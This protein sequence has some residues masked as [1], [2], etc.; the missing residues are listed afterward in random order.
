MDKLQVRNSKSARI[1]TVAVVGADGSG[2]STVI[3]NI[4]QSSVEPVKCV[5]MGASVDASNVSLPTT[6]LLQYIKKRRMAHFVDT[7]GRLP[8]ATLMSEEMRAKMPRGKIAK[9]VG[10]VNRVAEEWYRQLHVWAYQLRG[11]SV[12]C[13]RHFL[14]EYCPDAVSI[15]AKDQWLSV[16]I[17]SWLLRRLFPKPDLVI[18]L[19]APV[20]TL[21]ARKSE[22]PLEHLERQRA[23][24]IEQGRVCDNFVRVD[25]N[26]PLEIVLSQVRASLE[27]FRI[28]NQEP[29]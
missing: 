1:G 2:K 29:V 6:R 12:L 28:E 10:L 27:R 11:Y 8:P 18:F 25:A 14:F 20:E 26:Q 17:H 24:I 7:S 3:E 5:Y 22:W 4:L 13:D 19:D 16:R 23:G 15:D 21:L 9:A